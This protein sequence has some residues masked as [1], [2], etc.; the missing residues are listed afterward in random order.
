MITTEKVLDDR[1]AELCIL[2]A[3]FRVLCVTKLW[4]LRAHSPYECIVHTCMRR[5]FLPS[6]P[7]YG[8]KPYCVA[9]HTQIITH[10]PRYSPLQD[11][12]NGPRHQIDL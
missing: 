9:T 5:S 4:G 1:K 8:H 2:N 3:Q 10:I 12:S 6:K 7:L 11:P